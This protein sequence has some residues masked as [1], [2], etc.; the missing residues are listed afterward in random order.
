MQNFIKPI[1]AEQTWPVRQAVM[2]PNDL[3]EKVKLADDASGRHFGLFAGEE[4]AAVVSL[5]VAGNAMQ[6]RKLATVNAQQGKGFGKQMIA[7]IIELASAENL[8]MVWCNARLTALPFYQKFGF[9]AFGNTW[10]QNGH[11]Y[12]LMKKMI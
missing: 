7:F 6:F 10:Q 1:T 4:L 2:Y 11:A 5:F 8:Q 9:E 12:V 3:I